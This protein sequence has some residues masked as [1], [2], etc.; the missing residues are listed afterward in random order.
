MS[1]VAVAG[2]GIAAAGTAISSSNQPE[3]PMHNQRRFYYRQLYG[4]NG[5][6]GLLASLYRD[7][8]HYMQTYNDKYVNGAIDQYG[9]G[10]LA[11]ESANASASGLGNVTSRNVLQRGIGTDVTHLREQAVLNRLNLA[12]GFNDRAYDWQLGGASPNF[13]GSPQFAQA[14]A[15]RMDSNIAGIGGALGNYFYQNGMPGKNNSPRYQDNNLWMQQLMGS[16][17]GFGGG[18]FQGPP[19]PQ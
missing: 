7:K 6:N 19:A 14:N 11:R 13:A 2:V 18:V 3:D 17:G 8:K 4:D 5:H 12:Q 9:R 10:E 16:G 15:Q 1:W